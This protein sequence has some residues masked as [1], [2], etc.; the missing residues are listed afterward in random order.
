MK[1][2]ESTKCKNGDITIDH[3]SVFLGCSEKSPL[4]C[5]MPRKT[6]PK[7]SSSGRTVKSTVCNL[8]PSD[9]REIRIKKNTRCFF[10]NCYFLI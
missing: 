2:S 9:I 4:L 1:L 8:K 7:V 10:S 5:A 6:Y 3:P